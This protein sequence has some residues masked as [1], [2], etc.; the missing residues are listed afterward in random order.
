MSRKVFGQEVIFNKTPIFYGGI[1]LYGKIDA[2]TADFTGD[3]SLNS[4]SV[5]KVLNVG[6]KSDGEVN[7][8]GGSVSITSSVSMTGS[9]SI[10]DTTSNAGGARYIS[11]EAPT[12][13]VG[14]DGDIWYDV[15]STGN[16]FGTGGNI[17]IGGIIMWHGIIENIPASWALCDGTSYSTAVGTIVTP[18]LTDKFVIG[19]GT[20]LTENNTEY[21]ATNITTTETRTGGSKDA[22]LVSHSHNVSYGKYFGYSYNQADSLVTQQSNLGL[23]VI[24]SNT[25]GWQSYNNFATNTQG[26]SE[27]NA[28]LP[29]YY[30]LAYIMRIS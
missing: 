25:G 22:V 8:Y 27:T 24:S 9:V 29:P 6:D 11:T 30:A 16:V 7:I 26:S 4:L 21:P 15:S 17:P 5:K 2:G 13:A 20:T 19:A 10:A 18:D 1:K 12:A 3:V 23:G 14:A 28:N